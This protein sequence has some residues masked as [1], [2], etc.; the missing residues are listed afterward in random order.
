MDTTPASKQSRAFSTRWHFPVIKTAYP[1]IILV[2]LLYAISFHILLPMIKTSLIRGEYKL[3]ERRTNIFFNEI[4]KAYERARSG[5]ISERDAQEMI[6]DNFRG[7]R[8]GPND[9]NYVWICNN[10]YELVMHP[11]Y[12]DKEGQPVDSLFYYPKDAEMFH[13]ALDRAVTQKKGLIEYL[14]YQKTEPT[15]MLTKNSYTMYFEPWGW[16]IGTGFI[17]DDVNADVSNAQSKLLALLLLVFIIT[18]A[19]SAFLIAREN[20]ANRQRCQAEIALTERERYYRHIFNSVNECIFIHDATNGR[21]ID[22]NNRV[23]DIFGVTKEEAGQLEPNELSSGQSPYSNQEAFAWIRK[24]VEEG[25]Q[26]FEWLSRGKNGRLFWTEVSLRASRIAGQ[27]RIIAI[28]RDIS[29][30][31]KNEKDREDFFN[32][33]KSTNIQLEQFFHAV[34]H[35]LKAPLVTIGG[36][37]SL[38][39]EDLRSQKYGHAIEMVGS[40]AKATDK[41]S[42]LLNGLMTYSRCH[43]KGLELE[44]INMQDVVQDAIE[45]SIGIRKNRSLMIQIDNELPRVQGNRIGLIQVMQNLITNAIKYIGQTPC[46]EIHIGSA[47]KDDKQAFYVKD[48]G[49]GI[50]KEY[51]VIIFRPFEQ[52]DPTMEG[53]GVGLSLVKRIIEQHGGRIWVESQGTN[54]GS[55]FWFSLTVI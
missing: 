53:S 14:W 3:I 36:F 29:E 10:H 17:L 51:Q 34:S 39:A 26:H 22:I 19:L 41:M 5:A 20:V 43:A 38:L 42:Q 8:Y 32:E 55:T 11:I 7:L 12:T 50:P 23:E 15:H 9:S 6:K 16:I 33:M 30:R 48:N 40:I 52:L 2:A 31:K 28:V 46:P 13:Q 24:A 45:L 47:T 49:I 25:P 27:N 4:N 1:A 35:D 54:L 18:V 44:P 37:A 21:I